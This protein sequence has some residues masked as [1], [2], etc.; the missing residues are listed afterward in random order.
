[1]KENENIIYGRNPVLEAINSGREIEKIYVS[2]N[3]KGNIS[4]IIKAARDKNIIVSTT[5]NGTLDKLSNYG[6]HQGIAAL[7][8]L[9]K[10]YEVEDILEYAEKRGEKPFILLLDGITDTHNL[11]AI[12]RTAEAFSAHGIIIPKRRSAV[13]NSTVV[14]TSAGATE[15][16]KIVKVSNIN[17]AINNL[18]K[19]GVWIVGSSLDADVD[20]QNVDYTGPVAI[21]IGSEGKGMSELTQKNCDYI[22]KIPMRGN[23]NSLNASVAASIFMYEVIRQRMGKA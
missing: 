8:S 1:M 14:K 21:V 10:Y 2:K 19:Q 13:V 18:K 12:I 23:I 16:I 5:D 15:Y 4:K 3:A 9:Y 6:N 11:G 20:F 17:N 7:C 22:A